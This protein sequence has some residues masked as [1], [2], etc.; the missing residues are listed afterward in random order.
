[1][2]LQQREYCTTNLQAEKAQQSSGISSLALGLCIGMNH[3]VWDVLVCTVQP[4]N[5]IRILLDT[6][7]K[8]SHYIA[9]SIRSTQ[10]QP[11]QIRLYQ[12]RSYRT[13]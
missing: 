11:D 13:T 8:Q 2:R 9:D 12:I 5:M 7:C 4:L 3:G 6:C 10:I 1:M